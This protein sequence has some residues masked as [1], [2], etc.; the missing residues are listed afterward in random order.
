MTFQQDSF[1]LTQRSIES[2]TTLLA[3]MD[4]WTASPLAWRKALI[5]ILFLSVPQ[6]AALLKRRLGSVTRCPQIRRLVLFCPC[7]CVWLRSNNTD[8]TTTGVARQIPSEGVGAPLAAL[9]SRLGSSSCVHRSVLLSFSSHT[10]IWCHASQWMTTRR[11]VTV[12]AARGGA[13]AGR[14]AVF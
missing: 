11:T 3:D 2:L 14:P 5:F 6:D 9:F 8:S 13:K 10:S 4:M 7:A 12:C 1:G